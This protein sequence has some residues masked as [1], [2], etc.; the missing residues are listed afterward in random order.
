MRIELRVTVGGE[1]REKLIIGIGIEYL[2]YY[3]A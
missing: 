2:Y 3:S 1:E